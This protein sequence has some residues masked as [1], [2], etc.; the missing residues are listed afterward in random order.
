MDV[1]LGHLHRF[2]PQDSP[3][4]PIAV[5]FH[6]QIGRGRMA[7]VVKTTIGDARFFQSG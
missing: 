1:P 3:D 4:L 7:Q 6:R 5:P 2:M